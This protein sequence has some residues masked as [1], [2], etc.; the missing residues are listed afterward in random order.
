IDGESDA[1]SSMITVRYDTK[2]GFEKPRVEAHGSFLQV[3]LPNTLVPQP[4]RFIEANS[5]YIRKYAAFQLDE[6]TAG[7]RLFVTKEAAHLL[8]AVNTDVLENRVVILL[9]HALAEKSLEAHFDGVPVQGGPTP[10]EIVDRTE[11]RRDI[12]DPAQLPAATVQK[13]SAETTAA[14]RTQEPVSSKED[15]TANMEQ[16]MVLVTMFLAVMLLLL[17]GI[18]SWRRVAS[19]KW[20]LAPTEDFSLKTLASHSIGPKQ[21]LTVVQ[22]GQEQIL[23]GVS[24]DSI[25]FLTSLHKPTPAPQV[26]VEGMLHKSLQS[27]LPKRPQNRL[28]DEVSRPGGRPARTSSQPLPEP[29]SG[30]SYGISDEGVKNYKTPGTSRTPSDPTAVEDVTKLIRKKLRDLPK[31]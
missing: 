10:E 27:P 25:N 12:P 21:K 5:P 15:W 3:I 22:V 2:P 31:V 28:V 19:K 1:K 23:I 11:I 7:I 16:K 6:Q 18:K 14:P 26:S 29:G 17:I 30:I 13:Q 9:D 20:P 8:S 24:P 4:G